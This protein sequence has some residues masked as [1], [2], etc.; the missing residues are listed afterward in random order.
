MLQFYRV[1]RQ[2]NIRDT[3]DMD[4]INTMVASSAMNA[5]L[6]NAITPGRTSTPKCTNPEVSTLP[7][8]SKKKLKINATAG[9]GKLNNI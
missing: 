1:L 7:T 3:I 9:G 4:L 2:N 6:A 5:L 8:A